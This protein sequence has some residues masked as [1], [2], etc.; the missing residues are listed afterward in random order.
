M[1]R[2]LAFGSHPDDVEF[3]CAGTLALLAR[4]GHEIH[5]AVMAG[6]EMGSPELPPQQIREKRLKE[7]QAS[8]EVIGAK[9]HYAGGYDLE[10][11]YNA[12]YRRRTVQVVREADPTVLFAPPPADYLIDHEET[13][14]LVR[15]AAF[16]APVPN[17]DCGVPT[18]PIAR[19]PYLYYWNAVGLKDIFGRSL[20]LT[21]FVNI[22]ATLGVKEKMLACHASQRQW[23][24]FINGCDEYLQMM[25]R[26]AV[27]EGRRAG[28]AAA[29]G[30]IQHVGN[31]HPPE[32]VLTK[33]LGELC[34]DVEGAKG[35][36]GP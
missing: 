36:K 8:A 23:L 31:G 34:C 22:A 15:N 24:R 7:A 13:S 30:F 2:I 21:C 27:D 32:N 19:I 18:R 25:H 17:Y 28:C 11:E 20:P 35:A 26:M 14:R 5:I 1:E 3:M 6:G 9:F 4:A 10:V 16:I 12:E 33:L 29:E